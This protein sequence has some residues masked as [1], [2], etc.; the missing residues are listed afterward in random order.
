MLNHL[1]LLSPITAMDVLGKKPFSDLMSVDTLIE[2][3][4][5]ISGQK[6]NDFIDMTIQYL[7]EAPSSSKTQI[8]KKTIASGLYELLINAGEEVIASHPNL[9]TIPDQLKALNADPVRT[10]SLSH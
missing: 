7:N 1:L 6:P 5:D 4:E 8:V 9:N 2:K 10:S 3:L